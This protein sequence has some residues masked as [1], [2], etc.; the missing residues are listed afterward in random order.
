MAV[1][2]LHACMHT[3]IHD[4]YINPKSVGLTE[5][6]KPNLVARAMRVEMNDPNNPIPTSDQSESNSGS[7]LF[8][9]RHKNK[10]KAKLVLFFLEKV[11]VSFAI[12]Q[13]KG[14]TTKT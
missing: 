14:L 1:T 8:A 5:F 10:S 4:T 9:F 13:A 2:C 11:V 6:M 12:M 3:Y 7:L